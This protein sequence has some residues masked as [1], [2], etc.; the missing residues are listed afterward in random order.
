MAPARDLGAGM[1]AVDYGADAVYIGGPAF[2]ARRAAANTVEDIARL[3]EYAHR[4]GVRVYVALNTLVFDDEL[5]DAERIAREVAAAGADALIVQDMA[6]RRMGIEGVAMHASTQTTNLSPGRVRFLG[7]A[8][9]SRVIL[10]RGLS[11]DEIHAVRAATDAELEVFVHG[12]ICVCYSGMCYMSRSLGARS[13]N[14]GECS[15]PCRLPYDLVDAGGKTLVTGKHLLSLRDLNL[16]GRLGELV[17]AGVTSFKIEGRLKDDNYVRNTV[18]HYRRALD[19]V[20][21]AR[22]GLRRASAGVSHFDFEPDPAKSFARGATEYYFDGRAAGA[23]SFDTPKSF[24]EAVGRVV[25]TRRGGFEIELLPGVTL[26]P[27]D[28]LCFMAGGALRGTYVNGVEGARIVPASMEFVAP[29]VELFRNHDHRFAQ[30]LARSRV[31]R[32]IDATVRAC[33]SLEGIELTVT[34]SEG[35]ETTCTHRADFTEARDPQAAEASLRTQL[36]KGGDTIFRI[37]AVRVE[38]PGAMPFVPVSVANG[39]RREALEALERMR[40]EQYRRPSPSAENTAFP[41]PAQRLDATANVV[42]RLATDFYRDHGVAEI[43]PGHDLRTDFSGVCVLSTP[44]CIRR[45]IGECLREDPSLCGE[46]FLRRGREQ[47]RLEFDC[48]RCVMN[49]IR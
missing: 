17:D 26:V 28:G 34:D 21:A 14:R 6:F 25:S 19:E 43:E 37:A 44:Y 48:N 1:C 13:G 38:A 30:A 15:Q 7:E 41:Y 47:F 29:G 32:K 10:E 5:A 9:F 40:L 20:I 8:G 46:L 23:A 49:V 3:A 16:G 4:F 24:G 45:E 2:G 11:L 33:V 18:A 35:V 12:A 42:N 36:A 27:G 22:P 31:V 39:V